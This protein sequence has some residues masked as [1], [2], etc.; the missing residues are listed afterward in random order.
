MPAAADPGRG[1]CRAG[2]LRLVACPA[3]EARM[4]SEE[5]LATGRFPRSTKYHPDWVLAGVSGG[6]NPLW[7]TEWLGEAPDPRPRL[8]GV[9]LGGGGGVSSIFLPREVG[10]PGWAAHPWVSPP[11]KLPRLPNARGGGGGVPG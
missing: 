5:R 3:T 9:D 6:A 8:R 1:V 10:G 7:L 11:G 4:A 2:P